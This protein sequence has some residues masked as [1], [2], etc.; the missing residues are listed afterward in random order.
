MILTAS[1]G[2]LEAVLFPILFFLILSCASSSNPDPID[3]S[4]DKFFEDYYKKGEIKSIREG[5]P[6]AVTKSGEKESC[7]DFC[8]IFVAN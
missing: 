1:C 3:V 2:C 4:I 5:G 6:T 7:K 8:N